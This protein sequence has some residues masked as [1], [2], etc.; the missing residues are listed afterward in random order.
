MGVKAD[1]ISN[2][3]SA[4]S[5]IEKLLADEGFLDGFVRFSEIVIKTVSSGGNIYIC[6]N[7]GSHCDAMHFAEELTGRYRKSRPPLGA[8][9]LGDSSHLTCVGNDFGFDHV[10]SRQLGGLGRSGDLLV[11]ISTSGNSK[12]VLNA[13][14]VAREKGMSAVGLLGR[15]GGVARDLVDVSVVV[16]EF[17]TDRIQE[18]HIKL[19]HSVIEVL[20]KSRFPE[21]Y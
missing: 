18:I 9:A 3:N 12:N 11:A 16:P 20:E 19:I 2:L 5:L 13:I 6:G 7:G 15:D 14:H 10:F 1:L 21:L 17:A 8:L 4:K